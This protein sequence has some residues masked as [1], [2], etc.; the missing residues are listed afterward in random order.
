[1]S[2]G[3]V[4]AFNYMAQTLGCIVMGHVS[5]RYGRKNVSDMTPSAAEDIFFQKALDRSVLL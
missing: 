2:A 1:V 4:L 5:D 3:V